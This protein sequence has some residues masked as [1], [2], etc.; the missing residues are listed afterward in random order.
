[1]AEWDVV[2]SPEGVGG[3]ADGPGDLIEQNNSRPVSVEMVDRPMRVLYVDGYPRWEQRYLKNLLIREK[4]IQSSNLLLAPDRRYTQEGDV[5]LA[6][7]PD[8]PEGWAEYDA[9]FLGDVRPDVFTVEQLTLLREHIATRGAG[10]IFIAGDGVMPGEWWTTP[11]GDLLPFTQQAAG[12]DGR[13]AASGAITEGVL[14]RPTEQAE[15][16][17]VLRL[18]PTPEDP[19]PAALSDPRSGWSLLRWAQRIDASQL[20]PT[21]QVLAEWVTTDGADAGPIVISMRY[22]A[23]RSLYVAT[24]ETWRWRYG[25]GELLPER[26]WLQMVRMLGRSSLARSGRAAILEVTPRRATT[27]SPVRISVELID[28]SITDLG[29]SSIAVKVARR[30]SEGAAAD[31]AETEITLQPERVGGRIYS[32][33]WIP[34]DPGVWDIRVSESDLALSELTESVEVFFPDDELRTPETDHPLLARLSEESDGQRIAPDDLQ[35]LPEHLRSRQRVTLS[36]RYESLWDSPLA[37]ILLILL[38]TVEWVGR[39]VI[40][41]L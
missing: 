33:T 14:I 34:S 19:W 5:I 9:V 7:L 12:P 39:R 22:G 11:L 38:L 21:A 41:L 35:T 4:T 3:F 16:L 40:R 31:A 8:S 29:L 18:G 2:V 20:K 23:G 17:G 27:E 1:M 6:A 36:E 37:L 25:Q 10:L 32:T 30:Q 15:R 28:Q 26:F 24:D 13:A